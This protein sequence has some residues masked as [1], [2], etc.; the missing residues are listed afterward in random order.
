MKR[1]CVLVAFGIFG[2]GLSAFAQETRPVSI[3]YPTAGSI[4]SGEDLTISLAVSAVVDPGAVVVTFDGRDVSEDFDGVGSCPGSECSETGTFAPGDGL[5]AG[6]HTLCV[7][8]STDSQAAEQITFMWQPL[9]EPY[10]ADRVPAAVALS[11]VGAGGRQPWISITNNALGGGTSYYPNPSPGCT[12]VYEVLVLNRRTLQPINFYCENQAAALKV[13]LDGATRDQIV[14]AGTNAYQNATAGLDTTGIGGTPYPNAPSIM[15]GYMIIGAGKAAPGTAS[16]IWNTADEC[17]GP[18]NAQLNGILALDSN[19]YYNFH[20]SDNI[21]YSIQ[22]PS[23]IGTATITLGS[24]TYNPP[25]SSEGKNG[26]WLLKVQRSILSVDTA[27]GCASTD[28]GTTW[29]NCGVFYETGSSDPAIYGPALSAL[30]TA[31]TNLT[32]RTLVF[33]VS[34]GSSGPMPPGLKS[35]TLTPVIDDLGAAGYTLPSLAR[36][37][38]NYTLISSN[39][40]FFEKSVLQGGNVV[41]SSNAYSSLEQNGSVYGMLSRDLRGLY[42]PVATEQGNLNT[43]STVDLSMFQIAWSQPAAWPLMDTPGRVNAYRYLS[44]KIINE[45]IQNPSLY[46]DDIRGYYTSSSNATIASGYTVVDS[47]PYPPNGQWTFEGNTYTFSARDFADEQT[48]LKSELKYL[49]QTI[50]YMGN[51]GKGEGLGG[52]VAGSSSGAAFELIAAAA[53]A[54]QDLKAPDST[55]LNVQ[56]VDATALIGA[57][58]AIPAFGQIV[59]PVMG[60]LQA[61]QWFTETIG[62]PTAGD[63][64]PSPEVRLLTTIAGLARMRTAYIQQSQQNFDKVVNDI[65]SD[66]YKLSTVGTNVVGKWLLTDQTQWSRLLQNDTRAS[67][68]Y[69]NLQ[70]GGALYNTNLYNQPV[71]KPW[72]IGSWKFNLVIGGRSFYICTRIYP[73]PGPPNNWVAHPSYSD[74]SKFDLVYLRGAIRDNRTAKMSVTENLPST[75]Y[76]DLLTAAGAEDFR[77]PADLL[78]TTHGPF[79]RSSTVPDYGYGTCADIGR[80][81]Y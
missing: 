38:A 70:I 21:M 14:I 22:R 49:N 60:V 61:V 31:L 69:F 50:P 78:L 32:S 41:V 55:P 12:G 45:Q 56:P 34:V 18:W 19:G 30:Q 5:S 25:T 65:Y 81:H 43:S 26:F 15:K 16:E 40:P 73:D 23:G 79:P 6:P 51:A 29:N 77:L 54:N 62:T 8:L 66:W 9:I 67:R 80:V 3:T 71:D 33:L 76:M 58:T 53:G 24:K 72:L 17:C 39:D 27:N 20:P 10:A 59:T 13:D 28:G 35:S 1:I 7:G 74:G 57:V 11:T 52:A 46:L 42:R 75:R 4:V 48:Q 2:C 64:I 63:G 37:G 47:V 36:T 44:N 68:L